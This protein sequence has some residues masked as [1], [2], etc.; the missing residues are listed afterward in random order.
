MI[1]PFKDWS[2]R[3]S[4]GYL[5]SDFGGIIHTY[6]QTVSYKVLFQ[7]D[8]SAKIKKKKK[9]KYIVSTHDDDQLRVSRKFTFCTKKD[10][11]RWRDN[12]LLINHSLG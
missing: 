8:Q 1:S 5:I 4:P 7:N 12:L 11:P 3:S 6:I 2:M 9:K 10:I